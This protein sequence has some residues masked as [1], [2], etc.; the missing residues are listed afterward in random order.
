MFHWFL[1]KYNINLV[2]NRNSE[3][4]FIQNYKRVFK[5][6]M[7]FA[8]LFMSM[9]LGERNYVQLAILFMWSSGTLNYSL[10]YKNIIIAKGK[11][12][13]LPYNPFKSTTHL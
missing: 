7:K 11:I 9:F 1:Q 12:I 13:N 10:S 5:D 8:Q 6:F 2:G 4:C 3:D